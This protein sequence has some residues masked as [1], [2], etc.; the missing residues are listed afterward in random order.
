MAAPEPLVLARTKVR[1]TRGQA[2]RGQLGDRL[3]ADEED[4]SGTAAGELADDLEVEHELVALRIPVSRRRQGL[5][6]LALDEQQEPVGL[7]PA[8]DLGVA[9]ERPPL[10]GDPAGPSRPSSAS[11]CAS[12]RFASAQSTSAVRSR[13]VGAP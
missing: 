8:V 7:E 13:W 9:L 3:L 4:G 12:A 11:A 5:G 2:R 10:P 6:A 1:R